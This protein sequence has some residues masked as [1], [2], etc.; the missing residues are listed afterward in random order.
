MSPLLRCVAA[1]APKC[2]SFSIL[3]FR[4]VKFERMKKLNILSY[5]LVTQVSAALLAIA[6][7]IM[8]FVVAQ[9]AGQIP[10]HPHAIV[11]MC[12]MFFMLIQPINGI[13]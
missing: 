11:G 12:L 4:Y 3:L 8:I 1:R 6:G 9:G 7:F 2:G 10:T 13:L 5:V